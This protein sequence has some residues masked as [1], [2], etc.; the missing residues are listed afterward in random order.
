MSDADGG[1][2][3]RNSSAKTERTK[4]SL[5]LPEVKKRRRSANLLAPAAGRR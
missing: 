4:M 1:Y 2:V 5:I 3:G